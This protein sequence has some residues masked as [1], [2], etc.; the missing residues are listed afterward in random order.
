[1]LNM[2]GFLPCRAKRTFV[3]SEAFIE[4]IGE[5][6]L[7]DPITLADGDPQGH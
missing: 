2:S 5:D 4:S 3:D 7:L 6:N 1:M